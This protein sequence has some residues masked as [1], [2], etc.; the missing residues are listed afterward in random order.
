LRAVAVLEAA[1]T[2]EARAV[3][4]ALAKGAPESRLTP[5]ARASLERLTRQ[6][7]QP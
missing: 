2:A 4:A 6:E 7:A 5:D 3:P 1:G